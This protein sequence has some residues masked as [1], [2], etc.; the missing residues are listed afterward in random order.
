MNANWSNENRLTRT[1]VVHWTGMLTFGPVIHALLNW[2]AAWPG[3]VGVRESEI[4]LVAIDGAWETAG[5]KDVPGISVHK[6]LY[7][8]ID[9]LDRVRRERLPGINAGPCRA[10]A[11]G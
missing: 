9:H 5:V 1:A 2:S 3:V 7:W 11:G 6:H 8:R 4:N 10:E